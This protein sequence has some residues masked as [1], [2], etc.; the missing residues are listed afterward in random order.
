MPDSLL[1][2]KD[3]KGEKNGER[4]AYQTE[5]DEKLKDEED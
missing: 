5:A 1:I 2:Q 3:G 4:D